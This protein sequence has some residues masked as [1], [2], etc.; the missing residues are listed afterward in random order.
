LTAEAW[1]TAVGLLLGCVF[2]FALA[3]VASSDAGLTVSDVAKRYRV[4]EDKVRAWIASG[5]LAAVNTA[6]ALCGRPRW[7]ITPEGLAAFER[8]RAARAPTPRPARRTKKRR[9]VDYY[10]D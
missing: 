2:F 5:Q 8:R 3:G 7:V 6:T 10:R 4:G 1:L 9:E